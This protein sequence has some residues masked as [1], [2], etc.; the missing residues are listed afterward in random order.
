MIV[1]FSCKKTE[2]FMKTGTVPRGSAG[3]MV[4]RAIATRKLDMIS[5]ATCLDDLRSPPSNRLEKLKGA[6]RGYYSIRINS[7]WRVVFMWRSGSAHEVAIVD[8]H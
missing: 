1:S 6:W 2:K 7:Q 4:I 8:Y 5:Y 3:W